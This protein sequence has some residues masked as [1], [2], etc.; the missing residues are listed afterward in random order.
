MRSTTS[1]RYASTAATVT[2][3]V[4]QE[5]YMIVGEK[6]ERTWGYQASIT[7]T[8]RGNIATL[9]ATGCSR[10]IWGPGGHSAARKWQEEQNMSQSEIDKKVAA[11]GS[12]G[13]IFAVVSS[14]IPSEMLS[15]RK[16]KQPGRN[17]HSC[18]Y[19]IS[20]FIR[21]ASKMEFVKNRDKK[22]KKVERSCGSFSKIRL[23]FSLS[24]LLTFLP[25]H[26]PILHTLTH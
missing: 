18:E 15:A 10:R 24:Y 8:V 22:S 4:M 2:L 23:T 12:G 13:V 19:S 14:S 21:I 20:F 1:S 11:W 9:S 16:N 6:V 7:G 26:P 25:Y 17:S 3:I 5:K